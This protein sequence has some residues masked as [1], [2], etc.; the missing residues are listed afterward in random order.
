[1]NAHILALLIAL[2]LVAAIL[3]ACIPSKLA[4]LVRGFAG[5]VTLLELGL[6]VRHL[7]F[8]GE[9]V[10]NQPAFTE[11][12][13]WL[14]DAGMSFSLA[15]DGV[16]MPLVLLTAFITPIALFASF[17]AQVERVKAWA[18]GILLM[19]AALVGAFL[20]R[21]LV[22]FY[23]CWELVLLPLYLFVSVWGGGGKSITANKFFL[24]TLAGS[25]LMLVAI[26]YTGGSYAAHSPHPSFLVSDLE[27]LVMPLS[28]QSLC[29]AAFAV[30]FFIKMPIF[31]LHS[32]SPDTYRDAPLGA[33]IMASAL[34]AKLGS[35]GLMRFAMPIFPLGSQYIGPTIS[36]LAVVSIIY[37]A[38]AAMRQNDARVMLAYSSMSHMGFVAFGLFAMTPTGQA[39]SVF[40][41]VSHGLSTAGMFLVIAAVESRTGT[42][43]IDALSG[44]ASVAP[45]LATV[46]VFVSLAAVAIPTTAGFVGET[47]I[48]SGALASGAQVGYG[49]Y[50][51]SFAA[52]AALGVVL[53]A[54]YILSL[55]QKVVWG[56]PNERTKD[57]A[58]LGWPE[59]SRAV[60]LVVATF[61]LG[62]APSF[63]LERAT[64]AVQQD[65]YSFD[66]RWS[67]SQ[68]THN[69]LVVPPT[70]AQEETAAPN[71]GEASDDDAD[72]D[73]GSPVIRGVPAPGRGGNA[74]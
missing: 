15:V 73:E 22:L 35:Y 11:S 10:R 49:A 54:I 19:E 51:P 38:L 28:A 63:V 27:R 6:A 13:G 32:W 17:P 4:S 53:G 55:V 67:A 47:M 72:S 57:I 30:A 14:W 71:E 43:G 21:D 5:I 74:P 36:V 34:M 16:S 68:S 12:Y 23:V 62:I 33:V 50:G 45:R 69:T 41:M 29:F 37:G 2:P 20:A 65:L 39:G 70:P 66:M 61:V 9:Y 1:M 46:F 8:Q 44:I 58:D 59:L 52:S 64:P 3:V 60:P 7:A 42:R 26:L 56:E 24:Y 25:L 48:L 31:P 18:A 40:Q